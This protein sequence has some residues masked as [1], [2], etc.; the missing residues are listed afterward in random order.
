MSALDPVPADQTWTLTRE[1]PFPTE[2][3]FAALTDAEALPSWYG[4]EGWSVDPDSVEVTPV[5][6]GPRSFQM[7]LEA[8][9]SQ[10]APIHG[11]HAAVVPGRL[12][13]IHEFIPD[14]LGQPSE[15]VVV[16]RCQLEPVASASDDD[17]P[18][19]TRLTLTQGPLPAEVHDH[20]RAAW[21]SSLDRLA[22]YLADTP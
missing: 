12:L 2:R 6:G 7:M 11:R 9:S 20:A 18:H 3:V 16:L 15:H 21:S 22:V 5:E 17:A 10:T 8:D 13:E 14:H 1:L 4:P 19:T